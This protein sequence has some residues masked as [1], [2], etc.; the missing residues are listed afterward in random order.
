MPRY[1]FHVDD[2]TFV[3]DDS[4]TD[5]PNIEA[6]RE[7]AIRAAGA[8]LVDLDGDF[9]RAATAWTMYVTDDRRRLLF[10]LQ[11][12]A[13]VPAGDLFLSPGTDGEAFPPPGSTHPS[14]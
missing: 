14:T 11:F 2:G 13:K 6:A 8:M 12:S 4:G 1:F 5:Y 10:T 3:P 9:W 7:E